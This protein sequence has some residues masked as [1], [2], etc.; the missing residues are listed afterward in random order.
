MALA[1]D[2]T[3]R[4]SSTWVT[5]T[6][7]LGWIHTC[8]GS[9][10]VLFVAVETFNASALVT[11]TGITYNGVA[12]TKVDSISANLESSHQDGELWYLD[13]PATGA[14]TITVTLSGTAGFA[15]G[16]ATSY[17]GKTVSGIDASA[18]T[19]LLTASTSAPAN[20]VTVVHSDCWLV[21]MAYSRAAG[22]PSAGSGTT[23]RNTTTVGHAIADSNGVVGTGAQTL[24]YTNGNGTWPAVITA[25]ISAANAGGGG[26]GSSI[27]AIFNHYRKLRA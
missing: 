18:K 3:S 14:N 11:V 16:Q 10:R 1:Y 19:Q 26:G 15:L 20:N 4:A 6:A 21:G 5:S 25:S 2:A 17:T 12:L 13:G 24:A 22:T 8:T 27:P 9:D 7:S 23:V